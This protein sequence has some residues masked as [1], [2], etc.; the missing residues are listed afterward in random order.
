MI[1]VFVAARNAPHSTSNCLGSLMRAFDDLGRPAIEYVLIDDGSASQHQIPEL[2]RSFRDSVT[3]APT[4]IVR[5][6]QREH[7]NH[8]MALGL[9]LA[10]G[11]LV[12][13]VSHDMVATPDYVQTLLRV[14]ALDPT[15]GIVRGTST[16]V[17]MFPQYSVPTPFPLR[18]YEDVAEFSAYVARYWGLTAVEDNFLIGDSMLIRRS[19][20]DKIGVFDTRPY[21]FLGDFDFALRAQRV[22]LKLVCARGS[23]LY[24]EGG[25]SRASVEDDIMGTVRAAYAKFREKWGP[26]LPEQYPDHNLLEFDFPRLRALPPL[27]GGEYQPP[28]ALDPVRH[29]EL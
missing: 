26:Q 20:L 27:P 12:L 23:W 21:G 13:F 10:R 22:G 5:C 8:V 11:E 25:A 4:R 16:R 19:V 17:D 7:Y 6:R 2:F 28:L 15:F 14:A 9:S 18:R 24:H 3:W 29:E 1:T